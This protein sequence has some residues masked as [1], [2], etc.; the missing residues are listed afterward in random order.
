MSQIVNYLSTHFSFP[1][2][3]QPFL[4]KLSTYDWVQKIQENPNLTAFTLAIGALGY[5]TMIQD[6][7]LSL[8]LYPG[9]PKNAF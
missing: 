8:F 7:H 4:D 6:A 2:A 1:E 3:I 5:L 9:I